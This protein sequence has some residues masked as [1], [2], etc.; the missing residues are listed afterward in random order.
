M[1]SN[2]IRGVKKMARAKDI[3]E[4]TL[5]AAQLVAYEGLTVMETAKQTDVPR[6]TTHWRLRNILERV[7]PV[8]AKKV[9]TVL[10]AHKH[11]V[12]LRHKR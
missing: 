1:N 11:G 3:E 12:Y 10:E 9:Y 8:L 4:K 7:D 2:E 5:E 6:A